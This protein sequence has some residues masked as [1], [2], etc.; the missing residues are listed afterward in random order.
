MM[1][2]GRFMNRRNAILWLA[3]AGMAT[4][5]AKSAGK[6]KDR[7]WQEGVL[8]SR[9]TLP[10]AEQRPGGRYLYRVRGGAARYLVLLDRPLGLDVPVPV[11]FSVSRKHVVIRDVDGAERRAVLVETERLSPALR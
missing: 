8:V 5:A 10:A 3:A 7:L 6:A 4:A 9:K 11:R 2:A 1:R